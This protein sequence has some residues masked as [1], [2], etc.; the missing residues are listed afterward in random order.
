M[1]KLFDNAPVHVDIYGTNV[2]AK[3][4]F[5]IECDG[6][7]LEFSHR[8][9]YKK[10]DDISPEEI[11]SHAV[12]YFSTKENQ[13]PSD[14]IEYGETVGV[15]KSFFKIEKFDKCIASNSEESFGRIFGVDWNL[16]REEY[17]RRLKELDEE[18]VMVKPACIFTR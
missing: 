17:L 7:F 9:G 5:Q 16:F 1:H 4:R 2:F 11:Q 12:A 13:N 14:V 15:T 6:K 8:C 3:K 18:D 10:F